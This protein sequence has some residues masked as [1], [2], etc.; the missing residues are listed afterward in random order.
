MFKIAKLSL[1]LFITSSFFYSCSLFE[2]EFILPVP[3]AAEAENVGVIGFKAQWN[4]VTGAGSYE[5]DLALDED[6]SQFVDGYQAKKIVEEG[7]TIDNLEANTTYY[8]RV[9]ANISSQISQNSNVIAVTTEALNTPIVYP[10]TEVSATGF[11]LHW[12]KMP[13]VTAY[14]LD[15]ALDE[16][17][18]KFIDGYQGHEVVADTHLLISNVTVNKQYFYRVRVK[19]SNSLSEYSNTTS[20][21]TTTLP[22]PE[23]LS[24][25]EIEYTSFVANWKAMPEADSYQLDVATDPLFESI[26]PKYN[27]LNLTANRLVIINLDANQTYYYRVRA[28]NSETR[29]NYSKVITVNTSNLATPVATAANNIE[30]GGFRANWQ[31]VANASSYL[32]DVALDPGFSQILPAYNNL[33]VIDNYLDITSLNASTTYYYRVRAQGL[34]AVSDNSNVITVSTGLLPAPVANAASSQKAFEFTANWTAQADI[35][36][37]LLD[38]ATDASFTNFIAGYQDKEVTGTS[39]TIEDLDFKTTYYYRLRAKRFGKESAYSNVVEVSP[40]IGNACKLAKID[41]FTGSSSSNRSQT[42]SYDAQ[43]RLS[44]IHYH[45]RSA[46]VRFRVDYNADGTIKSVNQYYNGSM[47]TQHI[48]TYSGGLL[49]SIAQQNSSGGFMELW[50]FGYD[51]QGQRNS[52]IIYDDPAK[53]TVEANFTYIRDAE[54][55]VIT[56]NR[57]GSLFRTYN[58]IGGLSPLALF[59]PDLCFFIGTNRDQWTTE[60][61]SSFPED[62][63]FRGFLPIHN[64]QSETLVSST[65]VFIFSLNSKDVAENQQGYFSA[66]YT[67]QGCGF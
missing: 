36:V 3:I 31:T 6:F 46:D 34:N 35:T 42:F 9:R 37:Y 48:Y 18:T 38:V 16:S 39:H 49:Q 29:S 23:S 32:L 20:V 10:A 43:H 52:W 44:E 40:C 8:Y 60:A 12:K 28:L 62:N 4:K 26:L 53:T 25:S 56:V 22:S 59:N 63:E 54:G 19:Q 58:Y 13:I 24:A 45:N 61:S 17:F 50:E 7:L 57:F 30:S 65:E 27:N 41:Y 2:K 66:V 11:R 21:F 55:N 14:L 67:M 15:V 64:I 5:I 51:A 47:Y 1:L 33:A